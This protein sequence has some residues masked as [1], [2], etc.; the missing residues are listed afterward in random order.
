MLVWVPSLSPRV[1]RRSAIYPSVLKEEGGRLSVRGDPKGEE[2]SFFL[3]RKLSPREKPPFPLASLDLLLHPSGYGSARYRSSI[4]QQ[5]TAT[6]DRR[7]VCRKRSEFSR[8]VF[9]P[10]SWEHRHRRSRLT[11]CRITGSTLAA[12]PFASYLSSSPSI[13]PFSDHYSVPGRPTSEIAWV[14]EEH[15]G[16]KL[17]RSKTPWL[18]RWH[19]NKIASLLPPYT[20]IRILT[21]NE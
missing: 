17:K 1:R 10:S 5:T 13:S 6:P 11:C 8:E 9:P 14:T 15:D 2:F 7:F 3:P 12:C 20:R 4:E 21:L 16:M 18:S 19:C